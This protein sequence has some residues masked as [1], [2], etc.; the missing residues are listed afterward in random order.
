MVSEK[1]LVRALDLLTVAS[2]GEVESLSDGGA[3]HV[4]ELRRV[5]DSKNIVALGISEK[6]SDGKPTGNLAI[7]FYVERKIPKNKLKGDEVV[8]PALP[9]VISGPQAISTDVI[10]IGRP[11]L[12]VQDL[13]TPLAKRTP[14]Q[15]GFSI[16]HVKVTAGTLGAIAKKGNQLMLLSNCRAC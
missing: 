8:P 14:I 12:E 6:V 10:V 1:A 15:P 2:K 13:A 3:T 5:I 9:E 16:G 11:Q 4:K 7:T